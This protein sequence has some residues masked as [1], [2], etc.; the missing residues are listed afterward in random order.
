MQQQGETDNTGGRSLHPHGSAARCASVVQRGPGV[1]V[2]PT[3]NQ[4]HL[5]EFALLGEGFGD[6]R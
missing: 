3:A 2:Q 1:G 5:S 4:S 6:A